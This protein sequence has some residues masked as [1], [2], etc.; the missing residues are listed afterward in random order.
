MIVIHPDVQA[1]IDANFLGALAWRRIEFPGDSGAVAKLNRG[2]DLL[3]G[4]RS[5]LCVL[6]THNRG[7]W[8]EDA[9]GA[10]RHLDRIDAD[11]AREAA[12]VIRAAMAQAK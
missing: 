11:D 1:T 8:V 3:T 6:A 7:G 4:H 2:F 12:A 9:A 5:G 10:I